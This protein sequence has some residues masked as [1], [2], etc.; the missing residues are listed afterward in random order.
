MVPMPGREA[1]RKR[2]TAHFYYHRLYPI[3]TETN[4]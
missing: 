3:L 4:R 2:K 1:I